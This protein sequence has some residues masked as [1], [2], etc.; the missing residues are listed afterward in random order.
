MTPLETKI[1]RNEYKTLKKEH[2]AIVKTI[3]N[4]YIDTR[5]CDILSFAK[6]LCEDVLPSDLF[7]KV[8]KARLK[9][10][11]KKQEGKELINRR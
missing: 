7:K 10:R 5:N 1:S 6:F 11:I 9:D 4:Y 8:V 3:F 2:D